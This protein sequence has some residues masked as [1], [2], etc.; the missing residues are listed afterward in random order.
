M[1]G[2]PNNKSPEPTAIGAVGSAIAVQVAS[3][4]WLSFFRAAKVSNGCVFQ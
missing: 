4:Q 2:K 1:T 3:R